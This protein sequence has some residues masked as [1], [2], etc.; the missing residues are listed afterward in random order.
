MKIPE[1]SIDVVESGQQAVEN[2]LRVEL[3]RN[4]TFNIGKLESF[5]LECGEPLIHDAIIVAA[6]VEYADRVVRRFQGGWVRRLSLRIPV[7]DHILWSSSDVTN[8]LHEAIEFLT[9]DYWD[10]TFKKLRKPVRPKQ[11]FPL[12]LKMPVDSV[13][14][15]SEGMD[16]HSVVGIMGSDGDKR[17][18]LA[19]TR[20][21]SGNS[22]RSRRRNGQE[23]FIPVTY[24]VRLHG[25]NKESSFRSRGFRFGMISAIASYLTN[26]RQ[27]IVPE[28][29]QGIFGPAL[30]PP[31]HMYPDYRSHPLFTKR[32][33]DFLHVLF[34]KSFRFDFPRIWDTKGETLCEFVNLSERKDTWRDTRSCWK[35]N[36][37]SSINGRYR[38]CGTCAACMLRRMSVHAAGFTEQIDTYICKDVKAPTLKA[39]LDPKFSKFNRAFREY[40]IAG[41]L[42]MDNLSELTDEEFS[43]LVERHAMFLGPALNISTD[44]AE[45]KLVRLLNRHAKEWRE[46]VN[47]LGS[48]S[49]V[50]KLVRWN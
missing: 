3:D 26:A 32:M 5:A 19:L 49:Y 25:G 4:I 22:S 36:Q 21:E 8:A 13:I 48:E 2:C 15:F 12:K 23:C 20:V 44:E 46:Y 11:Q 6:S 31:G 18:K 35:T 14:A 42:S 10:I 50:R 1:K 47:S 33:E 9:G 24:S 17:D 30:I 39:A 28:S 37:W 7:S 38:Q 43:G 41:V 29:G 34:Q 16:S 45:K 27:I 40:A